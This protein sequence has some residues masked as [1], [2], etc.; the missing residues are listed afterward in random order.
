ML[1][2]YARTSTLEQEAG[3]EAQV[4]DLKALGCERI[5]SERVSS[6]GR[7]AELEAALDFVREGDVLVVTK[8]DRLARSVRH[9]WE[10]VGRLQAKGVGLNIVNL[11]IDTTTPTGK[12]MMTMLGGVAEF[13]R[14]MMLER[15]R[16]G[17]AKAK[18]EGKYKGRPATIQTKADEIN[19]L[20][21]QGMS[22]GKIAAQLGIGKGS[23][24]R[25]LTRG[26]SRSPRSS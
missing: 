14:D 11:G 13:E 8:M 10:I 26:N 4:R 23:V 7:R 19:A 1:V 21:A 20:A 6:I 5:F 16:E 25:T 9:M 24:H 15:Q 17:I 12:L 3:L 2:G 18:S 22:M